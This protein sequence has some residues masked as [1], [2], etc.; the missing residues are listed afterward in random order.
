MANGSQTVTA[1]IT[2]DA[3]PFKNAV[4]DAGDSFSGFGTS[5]RN[6]SLIAAGAIAAI[7]TAL[8]QISRDA[9]KAATEYEDTAAAVGQIFG[10][11]S[12]GLVDF[13]KKVPSL[14]GQSQNAFLNATQTFGIFGD[15]AGLA[16]EQNALFAQ[17]LAILASDLRSF[18]GGTVEDAIGAIGSALRGENEPI[19]R[20]GILLDD[21]TLKAQALEMGIYDGNGALSAQQKILAANAEIFKQT[22]IQQGDFARTQD[23]MANSAAKL[24]A[25]WSDVTLTLGNALIPVLQPFVTGLS[26][27]LNEL[28]ADPEFN[29]FLEDMGQAL[30]D[31]LP[32]IQDLLPDFIDFVKLVMEALVEFL[33]VVVNQLENMMEI[34]GGAKGDGQEFIDL[35]SGAADFLIFL[36]DAIL[37]VNNFL[38]DQ[39]ELMLD[40]EANIFMF[41][42]PLG[43]LVTAFNAVRDSIEGVIEWWN[44]LWGIQQNKPLVGSADS[45]ERQ[46]IPRPGFSD[47]RRNSTVNI[48]VNAIAPTAEVGRAV[49]D[50]L[51]SYQR[52]GGRI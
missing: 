43:A 11:A 4:R 39:F 27:I 16:D 32:H 33:P 14:L 1:V 17:N 45:I 5:V 38:K 35:I 26:E 51:R 42:G 31:M 19:R 28:V 49:V 10:E 25:A 34:L 37:N 23:S 46:L 50:S 7:S 6:A 48:S 21:A 41:T 52:V 30:E 47:D 13:A 3:K 15:A 36:S 9:V 44:E 22:S 2:A 20:Y 12:A 40:G 18:S 8:F 29:G 24:D